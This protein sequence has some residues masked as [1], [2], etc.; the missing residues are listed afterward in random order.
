MVCA[1]ST[2]RRLGGFVHH[3]VVV[4]GRQMGELDNHRGLDHVVV[5]LSAH[6]GGKQS[7]KGT[8]ALSTSEQ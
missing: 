4:E 6:S 1:V 7:Q 5:N 2:P 8:H 3:I